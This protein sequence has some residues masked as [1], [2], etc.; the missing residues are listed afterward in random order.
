MTRAFDLKEALDMRRQGMTYGMIGERF[1]V[2]GSATWYNLR[3]HREP[4]DR[5]RVADIIGAGPDGAFIEPHVYRKPRP[6]L[7]YAAIDKILAD[8]NGSIPIDSLRVL[9]RM[10]AQP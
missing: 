4:S 6:I 5:R 7:D 10:E 3:N 8:R 1:G 2:S 9:I